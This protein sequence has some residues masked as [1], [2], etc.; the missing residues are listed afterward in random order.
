MATEGRIGTFNDPIA[1]ARLRTS[2]GVRTLKS[3]DSN[4][5]VGALQLSS[6]TATYV[7]DHGTRVN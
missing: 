7:D 4:Y 5:G 6:S 1:T 2:Q 3:P